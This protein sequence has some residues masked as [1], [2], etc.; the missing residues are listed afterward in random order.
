MILIGIVIALIGEW[1]YR[2]GKLQ[3][4]IITFIG[5]AL[6]SMASIKVFFFS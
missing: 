6:A 4:R 2:K 5:L 1:G 3:T